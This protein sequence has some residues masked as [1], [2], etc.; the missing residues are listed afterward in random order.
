MGMNHSVNE[1]KEI[2]ERKYGSISLSGA[3]REKQIYSKYR[4]LLVMDGSLPEKREVL[5]LGC[6]TGYKTVG[7]HRKGDHTLAV[8]L[9]DNVIEFCNSVHAIGDIQFL[10]KDAYSVEGKFDLITAFGFSLFNTHVN[11]EFV[12]NVGHFVKN[13]LVQSKGSLMIIGSFTDFSG[14]GKDSWYLHTEH[15][16]T[17]INDR[18]SQIHGLSIDIVFPHRV[19]R[20]YLGYGLYNLPAELYKLLFKRKKTFFIRLSYE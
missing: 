3:Q 12:Q 6:G 15:D 14:K 16:L 19:L 10:A 5:D 2:Y 7:F 8:D 13:H 4:D 9:S 18:L 17:Y 1:L 20:N 11:D